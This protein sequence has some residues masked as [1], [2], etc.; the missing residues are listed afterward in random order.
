MFNLKSLIKNAEKKL[1][2]F[3]ESNYIKYNSNINNNLNQNTI[4]N[5]LKEGNNVKENQKALIKI[6][7]SEKVKDNENYPGLFWAKYDK[8]QI[9]EVFEVNKKLINKTNIFNK[10]DY[11]E[12]LRVLENYNQLM[13]HPLLCKNILNNNVNFLT[14]TTKE[15]QYKSYNDKGQFVKLKPYELKK[16]DKEDKEVSIEVVKEVENK[17]KFYSSSNIYEIP[18]K[19]LRNGEVL[20]K[21]EEYKN[22]INKYN[23]SK[24]WIEDMW[25]PYFKNLQLNQNNIISISKFIEDDYTLK[26]LIFNKANNK[27]KKKEIEE[28]Q[29]NDLNQIALEFKYV[30]LNKEEIIFKYLKSNE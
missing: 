19:S 26:D 11:K 25:S 21:M 12:F 14:K 17:V 13:D 16:V 4:I 27:L 22:L 28:L 2:A 10:D 15:Y 20:I 3:K 30:K 29:L 8:S 7:V 9:D 1:N 5:L 18:F 23:L 6:D 24:E